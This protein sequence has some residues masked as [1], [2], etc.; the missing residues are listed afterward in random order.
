MGIWTL[1]VKVL[2][3]K[4][5]FSKWGRVISKKTKAS[6]KKEGVLYHNK[7]FQNVRDV[8]DGYNQNIIF[9]TCCLGK[10]GWMEEC[11]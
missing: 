4:M 9:L 2:W 11:T 10:M 7:N 8:S 1:Y 3:D 6:L 5:V